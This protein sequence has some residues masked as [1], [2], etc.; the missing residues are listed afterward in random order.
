MNCLYDVGLTEKDLRR[1][2]VEN[3]A[4]LLGLP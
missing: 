2:M 3:P 4:R 1:L